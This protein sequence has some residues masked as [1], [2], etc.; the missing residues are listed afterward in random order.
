MNNEI[1]IFEDKDIKLEVP[2]SPNQDTVWLTQ[3]QMSL[4]FD[5][6]RSS[7]A[8]HIQNVFKEE[9]LPED[10]SVEIFDRS[11]T[12]ASRPPK[13]YTLDV[14]ISVGY[15]V[16]SKRGHQSMKKPKGN[17]AA[18]V[19]QYE[20]CRS[21]IDSMRFGSE[22]ELFGREKDDSFKGSIGRALPDRKCILPWRKRK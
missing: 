18:Y 12:R 5:T 17:D 7:V 6:A 22:S 16:K 1:V 19:L 8:Y 4:L 10:T 2:V 20:E 3:E 13:Y 21:L 15:R 9:E 14:I 11:T